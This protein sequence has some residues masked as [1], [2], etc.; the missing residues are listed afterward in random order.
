MDKERFLRKYI[1]PF[2]D[3]HYIFD[4]RGFIVWRMGTGNNVELLHIKASEVRKGHGASL[5]KGM[6]KQLQ[7]NPPHHSV[8]LFTRTGNESAKKF[9][10]KFGFTLV[11]VGDLYAEGGTTIGVVSFAELKRRMDVR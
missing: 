7:D 9:Y 2:T 1:H 5:L 10:E 8:F 3:L 4:E 11:D 6:V